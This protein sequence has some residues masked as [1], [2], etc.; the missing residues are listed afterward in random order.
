HVASDPN[1]K[2][3]L[4]LFV[5]GPLDSFLQ[6]SVLRHVEQFC[7][8]ISILERSLGQEKASTIGMREQAD[9]HQDLM[10][11]N[12]D[13]QLVGHV[14]DQLHEQVTFVQPVELFPSS[15]QRAPN[16]KRMIEDNLPAGTFVA[17]RRRTGGQ[18]TLEQVRGDAVPFASAQKALLLV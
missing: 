12:V 1:S 9:V 3:D 17:F 18:P 14:P 15:H 10:A 2:G 5:L 7:N 4:D 8:Q 11:K 16:L 6:F 13:V